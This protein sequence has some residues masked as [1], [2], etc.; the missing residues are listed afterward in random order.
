MTT[1]QTITMLILCV[2]I[3]AIFIWACGW[4]EQELVGIQ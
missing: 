2:V 1:R 4:A 3:V